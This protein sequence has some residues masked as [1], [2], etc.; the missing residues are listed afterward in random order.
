[1][2][3]V[4]YVL[5]FVFVLSEVRAGE[6]AEDTSLSVAEIEQVLAP[7]ALYPDTL[8]THILIASTYPLEVIEAQRWVNKKQ[9][10]SQDE[11]VKKADKKSWDP[12]VKALIPFETVLTKL[13]EDISWMESLGNAF[14]QD[15]ALVL[16]RIQVLRQKAEEAG[17]LAQMENADVSYDN[18]K[19]V[20]ESVSKEIVYVP[21][22]DTRVVYG[23][24]PWHHYPPVYWVN[25]YPVYPRYVYHSPFYWHS[26]VHISF[27][28][29]FSGFHWHKRHVVVINHRN[30]YRYSHRRHVVHGRYAKAW[31][32]KPVHRKGVAYSQRKVATKYHGRYANKKDLVRNG[33]TSVTTAYKSRVSKH[34]HVQKALKTN[35]HKAEHSRKY[36]QSNKVARYASKNKERHNKQASKALKR[37]QKNA[38]PQRFKSTSKQRTQNVKHNNS[39][40]KRKA[41]HQHKQQKLNNQRPSQRTAYKSPKPKKE[42]KHRGKKETVRSTKQYANKPRYNSSSRNTKLAKNRRSSH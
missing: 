12:S 41:E 5:V 14:L 24:W 11:L 37:Q 3:K 15:E 34:Q 18:D 9:H 33:K 42:F 27:N 20:I 29:F 8:L 38:T 32:H 19:I 7:I 6:L 2:N 23:Y 25:P 4:I 30:T 22:Y 1:M 40:I 35:K 31:H 21:Y 16:N 28:F 36:V 39:A 13:S 17:S 10:L 26:G